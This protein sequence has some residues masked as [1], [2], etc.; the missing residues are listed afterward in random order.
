[1][2][3]EIGGGGVEEIAETYRKSV[4]VLVALGSAVTVKVSSLACQPSDVA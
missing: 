1:M 3:P 2:A 4:K